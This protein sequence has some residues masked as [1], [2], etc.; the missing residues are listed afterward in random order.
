MGN[1]CYVPQEGGEIVE[2]VV[3][4]PAPGADWIYILPNGYEY[5]VQTV[6]YRLFTNIVGGNRYEMFV[7]FP[8]DNVEYYRVMFSS[9]IPV[10]VERRVSLGLGDSR[11][12]SLVTVNFHDSLTD[13]RWPA[14]F[15][16]GSA[17]ASIKAAD[18]LQD[19]TVTLI[20]W[21]A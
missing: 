21:T 4:N 16:L 2:V 11:A 12:D 20:R 9:M 7:I 8:A 3:P 15:R 18:Q 1:K 13:T 5:T 10:G 19:I 14:G 17:T 6:Y